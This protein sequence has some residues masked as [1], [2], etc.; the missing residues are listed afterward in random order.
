MLGDKE[1]RFENL[2]LAILLS[3]C[4]TPLIL[5]Q[6]GRVFP[7]NDVGLIAGALVFWAIS[8]VVAGLF[9]RGMRA[10]LPDFGALPRA[11]I[12][13]WLLSALVTATVLTMRFGILR[14]YES[15]IADDHFHLS[16]LTSIAATGLPSLYARQ[17][18]YAFSYYDLD[19][20]VPGLWVRYSGGAVGIAQAWV[21]HIGIQSFAVTLFL[22]RL[23]YTFVRPRIAR[24]LGMLA[25]H[26]GT[27]LDLYF[28]PFIEGQTQLDS[29]PIDLKWFD[30]FMHFQL[31]FS[32]YLWAPQHVLGVAVAGLVGYLTVA[33]PMRGFLQ[34]VTIG[35]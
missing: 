9:G 24:L 26:L 25:I 11:D 4:F 21:I 10:R 34:F 31:P 12:W 7:S 13:A 19:Y 30:G 1:K 27:G 18:L 35:V 33:R 14:G 15:L 28:I 5:M 6:A 8:L 2:A 3:L 20:I 16:K 17:P 29:W 32:A 23:L 22:S